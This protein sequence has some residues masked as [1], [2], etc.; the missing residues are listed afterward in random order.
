MPLFRIYLAK[1]RCSQ[2]IYRKFWF[3][4]IVLSISQKLYER[5]L[6]PSMKNLSKNFIAAR[7]QMAF[8]MCGGGPKFWFLRIL[9]SISP[10]LYERHLIPSY[11]T[12]LH[13][14]PTRKKNLSK[15]FIAARR[16]IPFTMCGARAKF[17]FILRA[18]KKI[19][20]RFYL[21]AVQ[22]T[23]HVIRHW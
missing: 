17:W 1:F 2:E 13:I 3:L 7:R 14:I 9:L 18:P 11:H 21:H 15:N 19:K 20:N 23:S 6:I 8:T 4:R 22:H 5:H 12:L 16:Q 10:K